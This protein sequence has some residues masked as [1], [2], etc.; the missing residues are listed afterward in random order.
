MNRLFR[1]R[2]NPIVTKVQ[3]SREYSFM[4]ENFALLTQAC[5]YLFLEKVDQG[6]HALHF[7]LPY[8]RYG[9]PNDEAHGGHAL[10]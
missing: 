10:V 7:D 9:G 3:L 2:Q 6:T 4:Y 8:S 5:S 1:P